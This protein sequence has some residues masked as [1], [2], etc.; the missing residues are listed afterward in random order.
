[1]SIFPSTATESD[2]DLFQVYFSPLRAL[3]ETHNSTTKLMISENGVQPPRKAR[4]LIA[5]L[6]GSS[7]KTN[8]SEKTDR[9]QSL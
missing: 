4:R 6:I 5:L 2:R 7:P 3:R 8:K 1:M 9:V